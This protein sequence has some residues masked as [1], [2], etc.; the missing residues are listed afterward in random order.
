MT[1]SPASQATSQQVDPFELPVCVISPHFD[2]GVL[3]CSYVLASA[4]GS[5]L[6]T[7][8]AGSL[9]GPAGDWDVATTGA[10]TAAD[11]RAIRTEE[12]LAAAAALGASTRS[13]GLDESQYTDAAS[14]ER[15]VEVCDT[16]RD[17]LAEIQPRTVLAPLG[18]GHEDHRI[19]ASACLELV[20]AGSRWYLYEDVPYATNPRFAN[21]L[22]QRLLRTTDERATALERARRR[23]TVGR[24]RT[25]RG[26]AD[27]KVQAIEAYRS[28]L[29][30]LRASF[31]GTYDARVR[32]PERYR[33]ARS[34]TR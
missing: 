3:S 5:T 8:F 10:R 28:Q 11:A 7:V 24:V 34:L 27:R 30:A 12:D 2:D 29:G 22:R 13:L 6:L 9:D 26:D 20:G 17:V 31:P 14:G 32:A 15:M 4:P 19:V 25:V 16:L 18:I 23:V 1:I 33:E 21:R